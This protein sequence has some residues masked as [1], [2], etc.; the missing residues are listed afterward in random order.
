MA[1]VFTPLLIAQEKPSR[2][3]E[4]PLNF[5]K[6]T[7]TFQNLERER[8]RR[9]VLYDGNGDGWCDLWMSLMTLEVPPANPNEDLDGDGLSAYEEMLLWQNPERPD[10]IRRPKN[11][12]EIQN[13]RLQQ[14]TKK[15]I[16]I[17]DLRIKHRDLIQRAHVTMERAEKK[18]HLFQLRSKKPQQDLA[19]FSNLLAQKS[20]RERADA[21]LRLPNLPRKFIGS[22][23]G[24][25]SQ[26]RPVFRKTYNRDIAIA[27]Q[28]EPLLAGGSSPLPDLDG[29]GIPAV[30]IWD[31]GA[32]RITHQNFG[33]R[34][35]LGE[36]ASEFRREIG[37][38]P[39][40]SIYWDHPTSV[41][42]TLGANGLNFPLGQGVA[43][44]V[45]IKTYHFVDDFEEMGEAA[46]GGMLFSNHSYGDFAGWEDELV[47]RG[48]HDFEGEDPE[49][50]A[51][52][53]DT[54]TLDALG[55]LAPHYLS[56]WASG[57]EALNGYTRSSGEIA[58]VDSDGNGVFN[59]LTTLDFPPNA[60][61]PLPGAFDIPEEDGGAEG[62]VPG[63]GF[64]TIVSTGCAKNNL[65]VGNIRDR[66]TEINSQPVAL[67]ITHPAHL[68]LAHSSSRGPTDD[69]R[70]KPDLVANGESVDT[71]GAATDINKS[72]NRNGTSYSA[73]AVTGALALLQQLHQQ[74]KPDLNGPN[75]LSS[76]WKALLCNT[77]VD[78]IQ[79]PGYLGTAA[80]TTTLEGPD[81][82]YGWGACNTLAA[83]QLLV[84]NAQSSSGNVHLCEHVLV[85]GST[86][87]IPILHDG[88]SPEMK[89]MICWT[90]PPYQTS[91]TAGLEG[92]VN[93]PE[94]HLADPDRVN[95]TLRLMNDLDLR[96]ISP[97][98]QTTHFP[99]VLNPTDDT[100]DPLYHP[101]KKAV[102]GDNTR[103]NIEQVVIPTPVAGEYLVRI[104][105]KG[106]LKSLQLITTQQPGT[107]LPE[108]A[109]FQLLT[110]QTQNVSICIS[111]N[112][113]R[114]PLLPALGKPTIVGNEIYFEL[115]GHLGVH[116]LIEQ[117]TDLITWTEFPTL[118]IEGQS[119]PVAI[120]P[121]VHPAGQLKTFYRAVAIP[122]SE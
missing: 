102:T 122:T 97:N 46:H 23:K 118:P 15:R 55:Y 30:G 26:G 86:I 84:K 42:G 51:Y 64:D 33:G 56:V 1:W 113:D 28:A 92:E 70:I 10:Q 89:V 62:A 45:S 17:A 48:P 119:A 95:S 35:L 77:A 98:G 58:L 67:P 14:A 63:P 3:E 80:Q 34:V 71:L 99:W 72:F 81:Y 69:G 57:N 117:S 18:K 21:L 59:E 47:W 104:S 13:T 29:S 94:A 74:T 109:Q 65:T 5:W 90:D 53:E 39:V 85:D 115:R 19:L 31:D 76:S 88:T 82:F 110:G 107:I 114:F 16:N 11:A 121:Y 103:D 24:L 120:G 50:G 91:P 66:L 2:I 49:F 44:G 54:K 75:L 4:N 52:T 9:R 108:S 106:S 37:L 40:Q 87:E 43:P 105:H 41:A 96:V 61:T 7:E 60:G 22:L 25:D 111:G 68:T 101:L 6:A 38:P 73:P 78:G 93:D 32:V 100:T 83:A 79:L 36:P 116:Y 27:I 20:R 8:Q 12:L 112:K